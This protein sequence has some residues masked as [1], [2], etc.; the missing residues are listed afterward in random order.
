MKA[1]MST[2]ATW[3]FRKGGRQLYVNRGLIDDK[4]STKS[5][6]EGYPIFINGEKIT[7]KIIR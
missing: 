7:P 1:Y 2:M 5:V 3:Y 6:E 4:A